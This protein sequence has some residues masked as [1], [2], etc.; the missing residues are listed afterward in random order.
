LTTEVANNVT[1]SSIAGGGISVGIAVGATKPLVGVT[2][3]G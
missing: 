3:V 1:G 2:T